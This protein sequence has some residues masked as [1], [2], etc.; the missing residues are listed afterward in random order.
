MRRDAASILPQQVL[1][2]LVD[3]G[4]KELEARVQDTLQ[5]LGDPAQSKAFES[6]VRSQEMLT[7]FLNEIIQQKGFAR[8]TAIARG[9][10]PPLEKSVDSLT[11][12]ASGAEPAVESIPVDQSAAEPIAVAPVIASTT[13][14]TTESAPPV[15]PTDAPPSA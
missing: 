15:E 5:R 12:E 1:Q 8:L 10:N 14:P 6:Y 11:N 7:S 2:G 3:G 4:V 9:E 13:E